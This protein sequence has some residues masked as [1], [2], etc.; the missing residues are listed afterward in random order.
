MVK[1]RQICTISGKRSSHRS[2]IHSLTLLIIVW[3]SRPFTKRCA[4]ERVWNHAIHRV[5]TRSSIP[6]P[7][8]YHYRTR[9]PIL[10]SRPAG[11][12]M[13]FTGHVGAVMIFTG[14]R[15]AAASD[16]SMYCMIPDPF[17]STAFGKGSATPDY[18]NNRLHQ[19]LE[20][21]TI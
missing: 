16:N 11:A 7:R 18:I 10:K 2:F 17:P 3:R 15:N 1:H 14:S 20:E 6:A 9:R 5:V 12:V 19:S 13:I 8:E 21:I 4:G